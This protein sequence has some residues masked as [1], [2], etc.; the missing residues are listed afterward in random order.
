MTEAVAQRNPPSARRHSR[1]RTPAAR[2]RCSHS[3]VASEAHGRD[4]RAGVRADE[5]RHEPAR[6][7][8]RGRL[9][10]QVG[11]Q[12]VDRVRAERGRRGESQ[13]LTRSPA[14]TGE[15]DEPLQVAAV[16]SRG[17]DD[18]QRREARGHG[19]GDRESS[20][21]RGRPHRRGDAE[22]E[23]RHA[24]DGPWREPR[25]EG[26]PDEQA[27]RP[28]DPQ[29]DRVV[30]VGRR[31]DDI[32]PGQ[33]RPVQR[34]DD[35]QRRDD[36]GAR[37]R[38]GEPHVARV[39]DAHRLEAVQREE[40]REVRDREQERAGVRDPQRRQRERPW[41]GA[42]LA[43]DRQRHR[44]EQHGGRV[45][46]QHDRAGDREAGEEEPQPQHPAPAVPRQPV[47]RDVEHPCAVAQ[48]GDDRDREEEGDDRRDAREG[49]EQRG[50]GHPSIVRHRAAGRHRTSAGEPRPRV[51]GRA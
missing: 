4:E 43:G 33:G 39:V 2:H 15:V 20:Q 24:G 3:S 30:R 12:V 34:G 29:H 6:V 9:E 40:V 50:H 21:R 27:D 17:D 13:E 26:R 42:D 14:S 48:L 10:G 25:G 44:G 46:R 41:R 5:D 32:P 35:E 7:A 47:A 1:H 8:V 19:P 11:G 49:V 38:G 51:S 31:I 28:G 18:G 37:G 45:E 22:H 16:V 23:G 36:R